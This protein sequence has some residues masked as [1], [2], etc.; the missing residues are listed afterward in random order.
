[1]KKKCA[2][3]FLTMAV[4]LFSALT[5]GAQPVDQVEKKLDEAWTAYNIGQ[6]PKVLQLVQ[7]LAS[8]GNARAQIILGRCYENGLGVPQDMEMAAKWFRLAAEQNNSEAQV[9]LA[10]QYELGV[11]V[12]KNDATVVDLMTRAA[13]AGNAEALFNLAL[14]HGQG[15]YGFAKNPTESFRLAKIAADHGYAQAERYVGACYEFGVGVPENKAEAQIWY[16]KAKAQGLEE[17]G[18]VFNF[19]R[20]YTMP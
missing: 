3:I 9:L 19:V 6:Y 10:Y 16:G 12:P 11:G 5:A 4:F 18:N 14:Y 13:N 8:D 17:D 15:K 20:E 7:P 2:A 1:M